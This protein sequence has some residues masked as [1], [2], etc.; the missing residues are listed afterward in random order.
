M[1]IAPNVLPRP[2]VPARGRV[3]LGVFS[4]L[5]LGKRFD[6]VL[7]AFEQVW[8]RRPESELVLIGDLGDPTADGRV[9]AM[10]DS[11]RR[12][13][14]ADRIRMTGK[15]PLAD[16][17]REM[18][19]LDVYLFPMQTGAN[20]RSGTLP[21]AL[22]SGLPVVAVNGI[23]TDLHLFRD[24]DNILFAAEM[25]ADAFAAA[26]LRILDD[27]SLAER[28]AAGARRLYEEHLSWSVA[29]DTL[30]AA[31]AIEDSPSPRPPGRGSG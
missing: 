4:T 27:S 19:A 24:G 14:A 25:T 22:G 26:T 16:I 1:R 11:V 10:H 28:L 15:L 12:H 29:A 2:R 30:L 13:P 9:A 7:G 20:T 5:A 21:V 31:L 6:V 18:A 17:A 23:D 3:R 8:R